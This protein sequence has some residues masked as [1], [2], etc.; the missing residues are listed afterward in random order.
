MIIFLL[1]TALA[2]P[3]GFQGLPFF[4]YYPQF[5]TLLIIIA[6]RAFSMDYRFL[7]RERQ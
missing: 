3:R 1:P 7:A 6:Q 2:Y 4:G 5:F